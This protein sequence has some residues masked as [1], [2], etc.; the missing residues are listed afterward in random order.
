MKIQNV[1]PQGDVQPAALNFRL[2]KRDEVIEV[3][4]DLAALL[5]IQ[6]VN[7]AL[8]EKAAKADRE[9]AEKVIA[10]HLAA[11]AEASRP[12]VQF[13]EDAPEP[14]VIAQEGEQE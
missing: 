2:V 7:W 12:A 3:P 13:V 11:L 6:P 10:D 5:L 8:P 1:S 9:F 4:E 14:P